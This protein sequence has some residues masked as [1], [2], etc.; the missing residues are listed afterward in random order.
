MASTAPPPQ[1]TRGTPPQ[2]PSDSLW[3]RISEG[4][5]LDELWSQFTADAQASYGFYGKD[6]D[7][8]RVRAMPRWKQPFHIAKHFFWALVM[9]LTPARRLLLFVALILL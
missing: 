6:L 9:K 5:R 8:E 7:W 1:Y 4:R 3:G 2:A